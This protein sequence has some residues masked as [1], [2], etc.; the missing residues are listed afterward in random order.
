[1]N[2]PQN[3][4]LSISL[5]AASFN[6]KATTYKYYWFLSILQLLERKQSN[7]ITKRELFASMVSNAWYTVNYFHV[8][9]GSQDKLQRTIE[10]LKAIESLMIDERQTAI[11]NKLL[12]TNNRATIKELNHFNSQVPHWFLSPW[13]PKEDRATIYKRSINFENNCVYSL[14]NDSIIINPRWQSYLINNARVLKD[15]CYWNL[16]LYLQ[17]RNPSVPNISNKIIR[18]ATRNGLNG[19]RKNF[20]D[21]VVKEL[22]SFDC[23]YTNEKLIINDYD[24]DHFVPFAFVTHDLI[25]NLIPANKSFNCIKSDKLPRLDKYFDKFFELQATALEIVSSVDPK[26]KYLEEYLTILPNLDILKYNL[27]TDSK[28]RFKEQLQPLIS[29]ASNNGFEFMN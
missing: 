9:F 19:Q 10:S 3:N 15:F 21:I 5:L 20:W 27:R 28:S 24:V 16:T 13:F 7:I 18:P 14:T 8:S 12:S 26:N 4:N 29:I 6:N 22:G 11:E 23:I 25:W 1:M 2:L 17:S